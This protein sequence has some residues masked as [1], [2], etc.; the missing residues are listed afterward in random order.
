M[1]EVQAAQWQMGALSTQ[2]YAV[3]QRVLHKLLK[4]VQY[5]TALVK[6]VKGCL[7]ISR[8]YLA[9]NLTAKTLISSPLT[10]TGNTLGKKKKISLRIKECSI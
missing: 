7:R 8:L 10:D 3:L 6:G 5:N 1:V 4:Y 2:A 9:G